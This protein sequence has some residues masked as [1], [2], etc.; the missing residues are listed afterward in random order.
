MSSLPN[1]PGRLNLDDERFFDT[2]HED[3]DEAY[4]RK[5]QDEIDNAPACPKCGGE[6]IHH[7]VRFPAAPLD[8]DWRECLN[9]GYKT[10]PE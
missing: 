7:K 5:R 3:E 8:A 2:D 9:C 10:D 6:L 1:I 4:E